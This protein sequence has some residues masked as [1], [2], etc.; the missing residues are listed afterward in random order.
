MLLSFC[1]YVLL[2]SDACGF[3]NADVLFLLDNSKTISSSQFD[4]IVQLTMNIINRSSVQNRNIR[5][6]LATFDDKVDLL[7][8]LNSGLSELNLFEVFASRTP[9]A[10]FKSNNVLRVARSRVFVKRYGDRSNSD[11]IILVIT[12]GLDKEKIN[13]FEKEAEKNKAKGIRVMIAGVGLQ[14]TDRLINTASEPLQDNVV[15][16]DSFEQ[17]YSVPSRLFKACAG[18]RYPPLVYSPELIVCLPP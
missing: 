1:L 8:D 17:L 11:N 4:K 15:V 13:R 3:E 10:S 6:A 18:I 12:D 5:T 9:I 14:D 2:I 16:V 7:V